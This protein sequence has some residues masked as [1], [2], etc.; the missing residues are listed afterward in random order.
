[1]QTDSGLVQIENG[2]QLTGRR[3]WRSLEELAGTPQFR[4]WVEKEFPGGVE[5]LS[6][7]S[8]RNV[9]KLMAASFGL[10]GL[11]ACRRPVERILPFS[12]GVEDFVHGRPLFYATAMSRAGAGVG[13]LVE[14]N[15]GRPTKIEGNPLHPFSQGAAGT[16][17]QASILSLYDPD[18]L[19]TPRLEGRPVGWQEIESWLAEQFN[20]AHLG[21]GAGLRFLSEP[22][23]SPVL[24]GLR[25][26][27]LKTFPQAKW[28]EYEALAAGDGIYGPGIVPLYSFDEADVVVSLDCD[29][30]GLDSATTLP[31][32][33]WAR[34]RQQGVPHVEAAGHG[35]TMSR[36][37]VVE[38][39]YS[40]T[41]AAADHRLRMRSSDIAELAVNLQAAV[42]GRSTGS[43]AE[44]RW[45]AAVARDLLAHKGRALVVAGP[46]QPAAVHA[47]ALAMNQALG[48]LGRTVRFVQNPFRKNS[49]PCLEQIR[50][51]SGEMA[52]GEVAAL[53]ILGG[54]PAFTAPAD[55]EFEANLKRLPVSL[56]LGYELDETA[57][58]SK[59]VIPEAHY[60]E[61]WGDVCAPDGSVTIQQPMIEPLFGGKT[62]TEL[63]AALTAYPERRA[64]DIVRKFWEPKLGGEKGWRK[65]LHDGVIADT[66]WAAAQPSVQAGPA[67][68][69]SSSG[70]EVNFLP[71]A[72]LWDGR[73]ANNAWLQE[74]PEPMTKLTWD[75]AALISPSTAKKYGLTQGDFIA[76]ERAGR[77]L[78]IPVLIQPGH[79]DE[80]ISVALGYGRQVCGRVGRGVGFNAY[81]IRTSEAFTFATDASI[82]RTG[83]RHQLV[84][85]QEHHTMVEPM[86]GATRPLARQVTLEEY[87][88]Q[89]HAVKEM[90]ETPELF[91]IYEHPADYSRGYQWGMAIDLNACVGCNACIVACQAENNIPVVGKEQVARGR[92]MLWLRLDRYY[93]GDEVEPEAIQQPIPCMQCE[94][95]PCENV[96]PVG[97]TA[98]SPEGLNDMA[99]NRCVGTRYCSNNCPYK[100]RRFNFLN[101]H[102]NTEELQKM[103]FNP[104]VTVRMRGIMEKCTYCVQRIQEVKIQAKAE[105]RR[106]I[107]DGE[108]LTACQQTCPAEAIVFG[109]INDPNSRVAK[110][111]K[112]ERN[113]SMLEEL[114]TT[115]RT[116]YLARLKNPNPE[117]A[118]AVQEVRHG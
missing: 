62:A 59:A 102:R 55:C 50:Q 96:C 49:R 114:N 48:A 45:I 56:Y 36:L 111:K 15:E 84:Q 118:G 3:Y 75:N 70:L 18:R 81:V 33:Q 58:A 113:Y 53:V 69:R 54:N 97:A 7:A 99:Y 14:V 100:V 93:I 16:F 87:I 117:L 30:L 109:N 35:G 1:M 63:V 107:R 108:I 77:R 43:G 65:A 22:I 115:P 98:H 79:A 37:Y 11:T 6:G 31:L 86:T 95:A 21:S 92:E 34:R 61:S 47:A 88:R 90:A 110:L 76:I 8:R 83:G 94:N 13:L 80:S 32:K 72:N 23:S 71:S 25:D 24:A 12:K 66:H 19:R 73:W 4:A 27:V 44:N 67:G 52:R 10:A 46:R 40:V 68:S 42:E 29:F 9:L 2:V 101:W 38:A 64:Y 106:A 112:Q 39:Q 91:S 20:R 85:T 89:P 5:L 41:G 51:L 82:R 74:L 57:A 103:V 78:E 104:E 26:H 28:I 105:G 60:L 17:E 116:T